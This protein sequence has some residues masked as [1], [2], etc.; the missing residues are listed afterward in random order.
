MIFPRLRSRSRSD[1][2]RPNPVASLQTA[3]I[4]RRIQV[5]DRAIMIE[6]TG[7]DGPL[8]TF[9][10]GAHVDLHIDDA[11]IRQYSLVGQLDDAV[12]YRLCIQREDLGRGGSVLAHDSLAIG[13]VVRV[14]RPRNAFELVPGSTTA[15]L[16]GGG[17]GLTPL[18]A[19]AHQLHAEGVP[20]QL[21]AYAASPSLLPLSDYLREQP[22][23]AS[24]HQHFST[25]GDSFRDASPAIL[26]EPTPD[27]ALYVCGPSGFIE[28]ALARAE[29]AGW[30]PANVV[31]E[32]FEPITSTGGPFIVVAAS[33]GQ[34]MAVGEQESIAEVL[35]RHGYESYRSCGQGYCGSCLTRVV[36]GIPD[37][38]DVFQDAAQHATNAWIS[39]C[40]S[41]AAGPELTLDV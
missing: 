22:F 27:G 1:K 24:V 36:D 40:S 30:A 23:A 4:D 3:R 17:V 34:R 13:D 41:R 5:S 21:H 33:S 11:T 8:E 31:T 26:N 19:M 20:F 29:A 32:S 25:Q 12:T 37:H 14:S 39:T 9:T 15:V 2:A 16:L 38:R 10:A 35:E 28:T 18:T 6:L 7:T